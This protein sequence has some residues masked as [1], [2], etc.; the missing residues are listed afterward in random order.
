MDANEISYEYGMPPYRQL[1]GILRERIRRGEFSP[2]K[3]GEPSPLMPSERTLAQQYSVAV[4]TV[5][6]AMKALR[7]E[8]LVETVPGWGSSVKQPKRR[9]T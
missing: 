8:G 2:R 1:A 5:R 6:R 3:P 4:G 9:R 7:E